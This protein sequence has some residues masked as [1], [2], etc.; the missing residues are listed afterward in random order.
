MTDA[1]D[2]VVQGRF[3]ILRSARAP[4]MR[5]WRLNERHY[6]ALQGR[7]KLECIDEYG[8]EQVKLWRNA[9]AV[10][11]PLVSEHSP[12]FPGNNL[13][14]GAVPPELLPRGECLRDTLT[15]C[16]P[17]W[18][19]RVVPDLRAGRCV[20]IAAHGHSIRALLKH[21]N[22]FMAAYKGVMGE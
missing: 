22:P 18:D 1:T 19:E 10:P 12:A 3:R 7:S 15:R 17:F 5:H 14:Y 2:A 4:V 11:P 13:K 16:L 9:F 8:V 20:L 21:S 6:G